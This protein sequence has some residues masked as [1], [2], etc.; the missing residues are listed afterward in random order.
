M[1][2]STVAKP[3]GDAI[4]EPSVLAA[5]QRHVPF[6]GVANLHFASA[7]MIGSSARKHLEGPGAT[8]VP[9]SCGLQITVS[10]LIGHATGLR[11]GRV[12]AIIAPVSVLLHTMV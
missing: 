8:T 5:I 1:Q 2:S 9:K 3:A 10:E 4:S 12:E 6:P 7:S 11:C